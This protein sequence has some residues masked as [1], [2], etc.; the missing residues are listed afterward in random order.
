MVAIVTECVLLEVPGVAEEMIEC[1]HSIREI[2]AWF[3][4]RIKK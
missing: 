3:A 1:L 2:N 4:L